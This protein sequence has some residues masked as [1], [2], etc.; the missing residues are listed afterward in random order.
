M[1]IDTGDGRV[2]LG[3]GSNIGDR[4]TTLKRAVHVLHVHPNIRVVKLSKVYESEPVGVVD[5][6]PF[7][8]LV[9]QCDTTLTPVEL[10]DEC[11]KIELDFGRVR[12]MHWGPRTLDIDILL[13][14][15]AVV[16]LE[17]LT[18]PH[19]EMHRRAFVLVPLVELGC[20]SLVNGRKPIDWLKKV[21]GEPGQRVVVHEETTAWLRPD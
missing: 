4:L 7:L 15:D 12:Q 13:F 11:Q 21:E 9:V 18:V 1:G 14:G 8:N 2:F 5:Q 19:R 6:A 10:L 16:D 3:L 17:R 20:A